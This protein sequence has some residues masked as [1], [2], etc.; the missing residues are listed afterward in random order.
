MKFLDIINQIDDKGLRLT[1][2]SA[3]NIE[4]G[5]AAVSNGLGEH[6]DECFELFG[7][8]QE[9]CE[10]CGR[11]PTNYLTI[12]AGAGDGIYPVIGIS[13]QDEPW[14]NVGLLSVFS[15][16]LDV[17]GLLDELAH[18]QSLDTSLEELDSLQDSYLIQVADFEPYERIW[19]GNAEI[20]TNTNDAIADIDF[21]QEENRKVYVIAKKGPQDREAVSISYQ[22]LFG[23]TREAADSMVDMQ[24]RLFDSMNS[25]GDPKSPFP[26]WIIQ[27]V[28][29]TSPKMEADL[30]IFPISVEI[31]WDLLESQVM[32]AYQT[33]HTEPQHSK[34]RQYTSELQQI[35]V[36][37]IYGFAPAS[38][39][40]AAVIS[41][42]SW[43]LQAGT[44]DDFQLMRTVV[45]EGESLSMDE[46]RL[47]LALRG[48]A[49]AAEDEE[50]VEKMYELSSAI[51]QVKG[52]FEHSI[53]NSQNYESTNDDEQMRELD[54]REKC[55]EMSDFFLP[56]FEDYWING[57]GKFEGDVVDFCMHSDN[58]SFQMAFAVANG[59]VDLSG[60]T[61]RG[62]QYIED[63]YDAMRAGIQEGQP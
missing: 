55:K 20:A 14:K 11:G 32:C 42:W 31:D 3:I 47:A 43:A 54:L 21:R 52:E 29:V 36:D 45:E 16:E 9:V 18:S 13:S 50:F 46:I 24:L 25:G 15:H 56:V 5:N 59:L 17:P 34:A 60:L 8:R 26:F 2:S 49:N 53:S 19:V 28:F 22:R 7:V 57:G 35:L 41:K 40:R 58:L 4:G 63:S 44:Q 48:Q 39:K 51:R 38:E 23:E 62:R 27:G 37:T 1:L 30:D 33:S 6:C 61:P 12:P 10:D